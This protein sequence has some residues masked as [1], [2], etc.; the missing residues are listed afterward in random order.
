MSKG[1]GLGMLQSL[2]L[3]G[4]ILLYPWTVD[5]EPLIKD[6]SVPIFQNWAVIAWKLQSVKRATTTQ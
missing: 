3:T 1:R 5:K 4:V 6:F 2:D